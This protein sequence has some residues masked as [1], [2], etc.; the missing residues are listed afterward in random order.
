MLTAEDGTRQSAPAAG[1]K[2]RSVD[3]VA[4]QQVDTD[5]EDDD[6]EGLWR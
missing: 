1:A 3:V 5:R 4:A 2:V 6:L